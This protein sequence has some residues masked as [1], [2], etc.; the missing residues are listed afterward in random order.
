MGRQNPNC[1]YLIDDS[2][3]DTIDTPDKAYLLGWI[4]SDGSI[5]AKGTI[6]IAVRDYDKEILDK[7]ARIIGGGVPVRDLRDRG[8]VTLR[9]CSTAMAKAA[10]K[11]LSLSGPGK[12]SSDITFPTLEGDL[13]VYFLRGYFE[14]DGSVSLHNR[15]PRVS[16][17]SN[18]IT[19]LNKVQELTGLGRVYIS[20]TTG[21]GQWQCNNGEDSIK[22]L[23]LIYDIDKGPKLQ[24]KYYKYLDV[25]DWVPSKSGTGSYAKF[26]TVH[27][28]IKF[29][30]SNS[31]AILPKISDIHASG[32]DLY[33]IEKVKDLTEDVGLYSTGIK[34]LP[35]EG[36]Y[37]IL[38]GRSS[39]S[40][41]GYSMANGIGIIDE[42]Y[43][44][45]ILVPLR[46]HEG[47][48]DLELPSRLVQLV[49]MPKITCDY[50]LVD[51]FED[52][53]RGTGGFGSTGAK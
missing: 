51:S 32:I 6:D 13:W 39:I 43:I 38:V 35:P 42:N 33:I 5:S 16:I 10:I 14:G 45:E 7:L 48:P 29:N 12:K 17:A 24:R 8:M 53:E 49:L 36:Y 1:K 9:I 34:V 25:R 26:N 22:F 31:N 15:I 44:G 3:L 4:A 11:H 19:M 37:F 18:S 47:A 46:K 27:G 52:T 23:S 28:L 21:Q 2:M 50:T 30:K 40:K 20:S 41:S